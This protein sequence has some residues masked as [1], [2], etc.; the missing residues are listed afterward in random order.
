M[1]TAFSTTALRLNW[2]SAMY[3]DASSRKVC[4]CLMSHYSRVAVNRPRSIGHQSLNCLGSCLV[5]LYFSSN[6]IDHQPHWRDLEW[7]VVWI[8]TVLYSSSRT[9]REILPLHNSLRSFTLLYRFSGFSAA[10]WNKAH[11][12]SPGYKKLPI[13]DQFCGPFVRTPSQQNTPKLT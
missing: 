3:C 6:Y 4:A 12:K 8:L 1:L 11:Q 5:L 13:L 7:P 2:S 9:L 10:L